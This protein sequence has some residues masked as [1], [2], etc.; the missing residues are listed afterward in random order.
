MYNHISTDF[1]DNLLNA[2]YPIRLGVEEQDYLPETPGGEAAVLGWDIY[3][4]KDELKIVLKSNYG[5]SASTAVIGDGFLSLVPQIKHKLDLDV[6][7]IYEGDP[8]AKSHTEIILTYPGFYAIAAYRVANTLGK[9]GVALI[10]RIISEYAHS[11]TGIDIHPG[12]EIGDGFCIDHGTGV[13][14]G[15]TSVI[16]NNVKIYQGVTIGALSAPRR[17]S[18]SK[19]HPTIGDNVVIY[20]Q[21]TILGGETQIGENSVI[22]GNVWLTESVPANSKVTYTAK[23]EQQL[24]PINQV[25]A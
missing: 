13:V 15:E 17:G 23:I 10:P 8:A 22:G 5:V 11:K 14:I 7:A 12:A 24:I 2:L 6:Q 16:G 4:L 18:F 1:F 3:D 9:L 20:A 21:A 25:R 19:R